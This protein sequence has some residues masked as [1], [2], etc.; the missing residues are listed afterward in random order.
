MPRL[1][2]PGAGE[3]ALCREQL[4]GGADTSAE[5]SGRKGISPECEERRGKRH[6]RQRG[7]HK[8]LG[9]ATCTVYGGRFP[10]GWGLQECCLLL[11]SLC[12]EQRRE[13]DGPKILPPASE[14]TPSWGKP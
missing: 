2:D 4:F 6:C 3:R 1:V 13:Q 8:D 7:A 9:N 10:A 5:S 12:A 14:L 11:P